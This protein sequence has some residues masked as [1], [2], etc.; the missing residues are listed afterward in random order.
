MLVVQLNRAAT[1]HS[2]AL[3]IRWLAWIRLFD[4]EVRHVPRKQYIAA[5]ALSRRLRHPDDTKSS[6][7]EDIDD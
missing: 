7:E 6:E 4:F 1:D 3:I 5:D 2:K